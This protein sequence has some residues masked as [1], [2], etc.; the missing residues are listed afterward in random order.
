MKGK[1]YK[2]YTVKIIFCEK[3]NFKIFKLLHYK[4]AVKIKSIN[5]MYQYFYVHFLKPTT[6]THCIK[7]HIMSYVFF[8]FC[9]VYCILLYVSATY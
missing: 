8:C 6:F 7:L 2:F 4:V 5:N 3:T 9:I 1:N